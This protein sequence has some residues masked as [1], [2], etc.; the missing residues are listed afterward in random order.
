MIHQDFI[1]WRNFLGHVTESV[2]V[3]KVAMKSMLFKFLLV[4]L[5]FWENKLGT[6]S[7][8]VLLLP[9]LVGIKHLDSDQFVPNG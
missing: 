7:M 6:L 8:L 9:K 3:I 2:V 4:N 5:H 1:F